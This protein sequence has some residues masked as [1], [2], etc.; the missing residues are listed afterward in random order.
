MKYILVITL[1]FT[2]QAKGQPNTAN[3]YYSDYAMT[4]WFLWLYPDKTFEFYSNGHLS[5]QDTVRGTY[6]TSGDTIYT[7]ALNPK[8]YK[9]N[10]NYI[11]FKKEGDS[12][13]IDLYGINQRFCRQK[14][15]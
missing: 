2:G 9:H 15:D 5:F 1:F 14:Q 12:C 10:P 11:T 3:L 13:L 8:E 7:R 4:N 6:R